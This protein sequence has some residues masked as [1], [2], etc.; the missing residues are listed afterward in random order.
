MR[1]WWCNQSRT[2]TEEFEKGVVSSSSEG[3]R[4]KYRRMVGEAK[5]GDI[6]VHYRSGRGV[7]A[8]S[9]A[10]E[11]GISY[12]RVE[13]KRIGLYGDGWEFKT[14]YL[15]LEHPVPL[16][17]IAQP[18]FDLQI[19]DGPIIK[20]N[21]ELRVRQDYFMRLSDAAL[22]IILKALNRVD[23]AKRGS[24]L[25]VETARQPPKT[26][27]DLASAM[28]GLVTEAKYL[29]RSRNRKIR[30]QVLQESKGICAVCDIDFSKEFGGKGIRALQVHHKLQLAASDEPRNTEPGDLAVVCAS[31]HCIVHLNPKKAMSIL[32]VRAM[33]TGEAMNTVR[34]PSDR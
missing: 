1:V 25:A 29:S 17:K 11:N 7:V 4:L 31:C 14:A 30:D 13:K 16:S 33:R 28:E 5:I 3:T 19:V 2:W 24:I 20:A 6:V 12:S 10:K 18:I 32:E 22:D 23:S 27:P 9:Q 15:P 26:L 34:R 8:F 21:R